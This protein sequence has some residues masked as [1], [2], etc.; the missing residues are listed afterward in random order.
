MVDKKPTRENKKLY[1]LLEKTMIE[2]ALSSGYNV[3]IDG[4]NLT[5]KD[6]AKYIFKGVKTDCYIVSRTFEGALEANSKKDFLDDY[7]KPCRVSD[8]DMFKYKEIYQHPQLDEGFNAVFSVH[9]VD[10]HPFKMNNI[11]YSQRP[12]I[13][14]IA[15]A[16]NRIMSYRKIDKE[17]V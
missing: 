8:K 2:N 16:K 9:W 13:S 11:G 1:E 12:E 15:Q 6:R 7:G 17:N 5:K 14:E 4:L 10:T 3:V